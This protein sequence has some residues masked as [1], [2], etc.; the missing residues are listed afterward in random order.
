MPTKLV[1]P[2]LP[3]VVVVEPSHVV[4]GWDCAPQVR[5]H[6]VVRVA[7]QEGPVE[8]LLDFTGHHSWVTWLGW[9]VIWVGL[10]VSSVGLTVNTITVAVGTVGVPVGVA[11]G[12]AIDTVG[13]ATIDAVRGSVDPVG[14]SIGVTIGMAVDAVHTI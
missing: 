14:V 2:G 6:A 3:R 5:R 13:V 1:I 10:L 9:S 7:D 12:V 11:I 8:L 4:Q